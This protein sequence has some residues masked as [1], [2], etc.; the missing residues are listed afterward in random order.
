MPYQVARRNHRH[1]VQHSLHK[2]ARVGKSAWNLVQTARRG[3]S[4]VNK[5]RQNSAK[6]KSGNSRKQQRRWNGGGAAQSDTGISS[7]SSHFKSRPGNN[8]MKKFKKIL[9]PQY[10]DTAAFDAL[11]T[12]SGLQNVKSV[13]LTYI[14]TAATPALFSKTDMGNCFQ[15]LNAQDP[16]S[17]IVPNTNSTTRRMMVK[18]VISTTRIK[19][20]TNMPVKITLYDCTPRRDQNST[21]VGLPETTWANGVLDEALALANNTN[22]QLDQMPGATPFQSEQFCQA[23]RVLKVTKFELHP[24]SE[25]KHFISVK[26]KGLFNAELQNNWNYYRGLT[27]FLLVVVE[28]GIVDTA[29]ATNIV[30]TSDAKI[31]FVTTVRYSFTAMEKSKTGFTQ[32]NGLPAIAFASQQLILE[33]TDAGGF[34][35][36]V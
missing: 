18:Q 26:P 32:Y 34:T 31:D 21:T 2:Y 8:W 4:L 23:Y 33:D 29:G 10:M 19:N 24:G 16:A 7:S 20:M 14:G 6:K 28:G 1:A 27:R 35:S 15:I 11:A 9:A 30:S 22:A 12:T 17:P 5:V 13:N 25:H 3:R 36:T